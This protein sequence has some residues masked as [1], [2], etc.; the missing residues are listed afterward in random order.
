M[1]SHNSGF[2]TLATFQTGQSSGFMVK[3]LDPPT[4]AAYFLYRLRVV[5][6]HI[7]CDNIVCALG[8]KHNPKEFH[9]MRA[10]KTLDFDQLALLFFNFTPRQRVHTSIRLGTVR[11]VCLTVVFERTVVELLVPFNIQYDFLGR[12]PTV[13][14]HCPEGGFLLVPTIHQHLAH[15]VDLGFV[16]AIRIINPISWA[17]Q[18]IQSYWICASLMKR[19]RKPCTQPKQPK[20]RKRAQ[21]TV[22]CARWD[23]MPTKIKFG[24]YVRWMLTMSPRGAR[25]A[26]PIS[27]I[28]KCYARPTIAPKEIGN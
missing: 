1:V 4:P 17:V 22:R 9:F 11:I 15:M 5:L 21:R 12:I 16:I 23:T 3:L 24:N 6:R 7:V 10:W 28:V 2:A 8:R 27:R 18:V 19:S 13:H 20:P 14:Q 26:G 25:A